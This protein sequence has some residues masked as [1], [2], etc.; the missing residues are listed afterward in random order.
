MNTPANTNRATVVRAA[1]RARKPTKY[2]ALLLSQN[3]HRF[4]FTTIPVDDLF[5]CCFVS[6]RDQDASGGFQRALNEP[7]ADDIAA[8]LAAGSGSIPSNVVL[9]AQQ[10]AA[11]S[12]D[13]RTKAISFARLDGAFLVLDGQHRLWGY[14][15][16]SIRHRVP[17]AIYENLTRAE[18]AKLFIDINTTQRGVPAA[19]LLDIK[20]LAEVESHL[21]HH[22]RQVFDKLNTDSKSPL[23]GK[24]SAAQ[25]LTGKISRVTFNRAVGPALSS[26]AA[27][28]ATPENRYKLILNYLNALDAELSD[29]GLLTR[30]AF[31]ESIFEVFDEVIQGTIAVHRNVKQESI[32]NTVQPLARLNY[33]GTGGRAILNKKPLVT[34]M[35]TA[36]RKNQPISA[37]ML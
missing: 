3:R 10:V 22:L 17:V 6:R 36:L 29:K 35:Q 7:R 32:Q 21:E 5:P 24:L 16:C 12:Y 13:H 34:L 31:F 23:V 33:Y 19:L 8:Y 25:S 20:E 18:E 4:Y 28:E 2:P 37:E 15:K 11:F 27:L 26:G 9:S 30:S 14:Q 1:T